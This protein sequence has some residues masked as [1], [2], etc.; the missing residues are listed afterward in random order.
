MKQI[1]AG[2]FVGACLCAAAA[3]AQAQPLAVSAGAGVGRLW[4]DETML[5]NGP[6]VT[7]GLAVR[8]GEHVRLSGDVDWLSHTRT[9]TYLSA[10]GQATS[11]LGRLSYVFGSA[12]SRWRPIAG[13]G[14]GVLHSIGT[15]KTPAVVMGPTGQPTLSA[16]IDARD[17]ALT[18]PVWDAHAG[19]HIGAGRRLVLQPQMRWRS[20][21]G[22][23]GSITI[24]PPLLGV[25]GVVTLEVTED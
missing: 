6:V 15:L 1:F 2:A 9:L 23:G 21:F 19:L 8:L 11:V 12:G 14:L 4:D 18:R 5:G 3:A 7:G 17:W 22:S 20:T 24:E 10:D 16:P 25:Q 13:V